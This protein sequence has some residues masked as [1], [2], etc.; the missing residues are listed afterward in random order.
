[1]ELG[2]SA[3][4]AT[5]SICEND[6][7]IFASVMTRQRAACE[8]AITD[9]SSFHLLNPINTDDVIHIQDCRQK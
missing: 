5:A 9:H 2:T 1:M 6:N 7:I 3:L 4:L 8:Q